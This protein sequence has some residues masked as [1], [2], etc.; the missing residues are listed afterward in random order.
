MALG[1]EERLRADTSRTS[2]DKFELSAMSQALK[3]MARIVG[4]TGF[5]ARGI[6]YILVGS[7]FVHAALVSNP[8]QAG[9]LKEAL[10]TIMQ[11]PFGQIGVMVVGAGFFTFGFCQS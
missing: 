8:Q 10:N 5:F 6:V 9:G 11:Q 2:R 4:R 3:K 7:F 1:G